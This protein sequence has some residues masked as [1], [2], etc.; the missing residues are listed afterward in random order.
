M[1]KR[2]WIVL[3]SVVVSASPVWAADDQAEE[4][5]PDDMP[6]L[7]ES[8][9]LPEKMPAT[10]AGQITCDGEPIAGVRVTDGVDFAVTDAEGKYSITLKPD[11]LVP[12]TPSRCISVCWPTGT[13]PKRFP[14]GKFDWWVR[15]L[16]V[17]DPAAV[18]FELV[19]REQELPV[20]ATFG[21]DPHDNFTRAQNFVWLDETARAGDHVTFAVAGGDLGYLG[22]GNADEAYTSIRKF[23]HAFPVPMPHCIGNHDVVGIHSKWWSVA[24]EL[25][26]YGAFI[27]YVGPVRWSFD[28]AGIHFVGMD[29]SLIDEAGKIQLG[30]AQ[31]ALDWLEKDLAAQ[32]EGT[33]IYFFAHQPW[34]PHERFFELLDKYNVK[35]AIGGHS[36]RN[37][38]LNTEPAKPGQIEYWTKMSLYTL[39]YAGREKF[40]FVDRCIYKGNRKGWD[41]HWSHHGRACALV[42][43]FAENMKQDFEG[44][45][46]G[47]ADVTLDGKSRAIETVAGK[48]YDVRVGAR[49]AGDAPQNTWGL[50]LS[51]E[52]G[53]TYEFIY[54]EKADMLTLM[55]LKT[56]F[57]PVIPTRNEDLSAVKPEGPT[58]ADS[59][60]HWVE[61]RIMVTP[62]RVRVLVGNRLHYEKFIT[63]GA[64]KKLE[65]F[66]DDGPTEFKRVDVW[67]RTYPA[68]YKPRRTANTG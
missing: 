16:D 32:P 53:Q 43:D 40:E 9:K 63:P 57:N 66:S 17:K 50:R 56:Y 10:V 36:H 59:P 39:V 35:L 68:D 60:D 65:I 3:L 54:D 2:I 26:G 11:P 34:S 29:F 61:M 55:G 15:L 21:T 22:F 48:T 42:N 41:D 67:Q 24:H 14:S 30:I 51:A 37:M 4:K 52:D 46:V 45:H 18:N 58:D 31:S 33:P 23:T 64:A 8:S 19:S 13:W 62:D 27:K 7:T 20:V 25:A 28:V 12:Y 47:V 6:D 49:G 38:F 5:P 44:K 1:H